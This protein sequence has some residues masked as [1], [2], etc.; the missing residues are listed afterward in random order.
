MPRWLFWFR[1]RTQ[2][3]FDWV[4]LGSMSS[5]DKGRF[6]HAFNPYLWRASKVYLIS[7]V[8]YVWDSSQRC[9]KK[10]GKVVMSEIKVKGLPRSGQMAFAW[11]LGQSCGKGVV[12]YDWNSSQKF[13]KGAAKY[14]CSFFLPA[15]PASSLAS[16]FAR[17]RR[18]CLAWL[19]SDWYTG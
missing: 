1:N 8:K 15:H 10:R 6:C 19:I 7:I 3:N 2:A 5:G 17:M 16:R 4:R 14:V 12:K 9:G 13:N 11:S 18:Y